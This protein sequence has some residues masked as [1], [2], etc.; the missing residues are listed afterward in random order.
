MQR[1]GEADG[2]NVVNIKAHIRVDDYSLRCSLRNGGEQH[3]CH[4]SGDAESWYYKSLPGGY[5]A[6]PEDW[7]GDRE[8]VGTSLKN[9]R[10]CRLVAVF[11][12]SVV[13]ANTRSAFA[14]SS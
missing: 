6:D 4:R 8:H 11:A 3:Q 13:F 5:G 7:I 9:R 10:V 12:D 1:V 14:D 2:P